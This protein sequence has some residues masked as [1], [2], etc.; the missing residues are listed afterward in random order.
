MVTIE[1][2][3]GL[4]HKVIGNDYD[5]YVDIRFF[6]TEEEIK[7]TLIRYEP[8]YGDI[9][10]AIWN[11]GQLICYAI[12]Y[13]P[14]CWWIRFYVGPQAEQSDI[15]TLAQKF[16]LADFMQFN[17]RPPDYTLRSGNNLL[18]RVAV[19]LMEIE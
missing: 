5:R 12:V 19:R 9:C 2:V 18:S 15:D 13:A 10:R 3:Y 16:T 11:D 7:E 17:V 14:K 1:Q 8:T 6:E 4:L